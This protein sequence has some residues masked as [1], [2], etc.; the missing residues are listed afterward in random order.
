MKEPPE[1]RALRKAVEEM[2]EYWDSLEGKIEKEKEYIR[3][4][5]ENIR[6]FEKQL[7]PTHED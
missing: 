4:H 1:I 6:S 2:H 7:E 5:E 3:E